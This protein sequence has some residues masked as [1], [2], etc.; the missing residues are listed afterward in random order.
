[1]PAPHVTW[2]RMRMRCVFF[3]CVWLSLFVLCVP[4]CQCVHVQCDGVR[5]GPGRAGSSRSRQVL[6][7]CTVAT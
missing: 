7:L 4:V 6:C 1:M 5:P 3:F 2:R